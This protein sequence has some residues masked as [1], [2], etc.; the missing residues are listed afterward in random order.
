MCA[1]CVAQSSLRSTVTSI[2]R[3]SSGYHSPTPLSLVHHADLLLSIVFKCESR[4]YLFADSSERFD[5]WRDDSWGAADHDSAEE[6]TPRSVKIRADIRFLITYINSDS[7]VCGISSTLHV[8][9]KIAN[10]IDNYIYAPSFRKCS[11]EDSKCLNS[12]TRIF[13]VLFIVNLIFR[14]NQWWT[15]LSAKLWEVQ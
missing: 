15:P 4:R 9:F 8:A 13:V 5:S 10:I 1:G 7:F 12:L 11:F 2:A 14:V 3:T 6:M